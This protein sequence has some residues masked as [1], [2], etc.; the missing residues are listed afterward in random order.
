MTPF[1][2]VVQGLSRI[3]TM[4]CTLCCL[5]FLFSG[6]LPAHP[7]NAQEQSQEPIRVGSI[8]ARTGIGAEENSPNYERVFLFFRFFV[9]ELRIS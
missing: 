1:K 8:F 6:F 7:A 9:I 4:C 2:H 3:F 5:L